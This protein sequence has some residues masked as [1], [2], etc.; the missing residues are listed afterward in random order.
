MPI[1]GK[2]SANDPPPAHFAGLTVAAFLF[3]L[4]ADDKSRCPRGVR[5][6]T[7]L[8]YLYLLGVLVFLGLS[9]PHCAARRSPITLDV[10]QRDG[11]GMIPLTEPYRNQLVLEATVNG[12]R[13]RIVL[14]TGDGAPGI[15]FSDWFAHELGLTDVEQVHDSFQGVHGR[16]T[17]PYRAI[18]RSVVM[19]PVQVQNMTVYFGSFKTPRDRADAGLAEADGLIGEE[20]LRKARAIVDLGNQRLYLRSSAG[21]RGVN[22]GAALHGVGLAEAPFLPYP[23]APCLLDVEINGVAA[24]MILDTGAFLTVV[25]SRFAA[26]VHLEGFRSRIKMLDIAGVEKQLDR[27]TPRSFKVGGV[28]VDPDGVTLD[29]TGL[30]TASHGKIVGL[31]GLDFLGRNWGIIDFGQ[32]KLYFSPIR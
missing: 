8:R 23:G 24:K 5:Q 17:N 16:I 26:Q 25:D 12:R 11:Y 32:S 15:T 20:F 14:D 31:I 27:A 18:A 1:A 10:I 4:C 19:G 3:I 13:T 29:D 22:L 7:F 2:R 28:S 6:L 30:Y 21:A 9:S